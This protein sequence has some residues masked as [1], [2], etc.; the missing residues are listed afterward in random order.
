MPLNRHNIYH[1]SS[2]YFSSALLYRCSGCG[3]DYDLTVFIQ[4]IGGNRLLIIPIERWQ[5]LVTVSAMWI[6]L[7]KGTLRQRTDR[8]YGLYS[9]WILFS[10]KEFI[11]VYQG[12]VDDRFSGL[13]MSWRG[14]VLR[15]N[16]VNPNH[17]L[18]S[19]Q[20]L[21]CFSVSPATFHLGCYQLHGL[22]SPFTPR[23]TCACSKRTKDAAWFSAFYIIVKMST[24][25]SAAWSQ[26]LFFKY[27]IFFKI[28]LYLKYMQCYLMLLWH[29]PVISPC[30]GRA[31]TK[32]LGSLTSIFC[33]T[34]TKI[35]FSFSVTF[36]LLLVRGLMTKTG[37]Y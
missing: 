28:I 36:T 1:F 24:L 31:L 10:L 13:S 27:L 21:L 5:V 16:L 9:L 15:P 20:F 11:R 35:T 4:L 12:G 23:N 8:V 34:K 14:Q 18:F 2:L 22:M 32:K 19:P 6:W 29:Y 7:Q 26:N 33:F 25:F 17:V 37:F 30:S 3:D